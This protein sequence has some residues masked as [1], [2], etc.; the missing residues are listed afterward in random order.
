MPYLFAFLVAAN[1]IF[2]GYHLLKE[3]EPALLAPVQI[4]QQNQNFPKTLELAPRT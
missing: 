4:Q 2:M 1:A 3:K